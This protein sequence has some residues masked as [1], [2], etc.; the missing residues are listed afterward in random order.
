MFQ[1]AGRRYARTLLC[2][3][4]TLLRRVSTLWHAQGHTTW[5]GGRSTTMLP[6]LR[7]R[8]G[9]ALMT[10]QQLE[11]DGACV[12]SDRRGGYP[13]IAN[14]DAPPSAPL[15]DGSCPNW[16]A[17]VPTG[18]AQPSAALTIPWAPPTGL[19]AQHISGRRRCEHP[20][21]YGGG[22]SESELPPGLAEV[23]AIYERHLRLERN[24]SNHTVRAYRADIAS[25]LDHA[26]RLGVEDVADIDLTTLRSW[27]AKQKTTGKSRTT[28]AR[29]AT[30]VRVFT[31]WLARTGRTATDPGSA[32]VSP[33]LPRSLPPVLRHDEA[34]AALEGH[35]RSTRPTAE[36][37]PTSS[38]SD[39]PTTAPRGEAG[40]T[41]PQ[42]QPLAWAVQLRDDAM[43][44]LLYATGMRVGELCALDERD[45][46]FHRNVVRVFGKGRR[47]RSI[48]FGQ[49]AADA[50]QAWL[51]EGRPTIV[52]HA[53]AQV[54]REAVFLGVRGRR[55]D[56]RVVRQVVHDR[57]RQVP[58]APDIGPHGLRHSAATHLLEGG[59]DLRSVQELLGHS[60]LATTQIYTHVST[61]R[62]RAAYRQAH[63][64]A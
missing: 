11:F 37:E 10:A 30:A 47:E 1:P 51:A 6:H 15:P 55:I 26:H 46:D 9:E 49:P 8:A 63:P 32:L 22:V 25:M 34:A 31:G 23:L 7:G 28:M 21:T 52:E 56:Q 33:K 16:R 35:S 27:L 2:R 54:T 53:T 38:A 57:M 64:R 3:A 62:L 61:D 29:R 17:V 58:G 50:L 13:S 24:L 4:S 41:R 39:D 18:T 43:L 12:E 36:P 42:P 59:A 19:A 5:R 45:L 20:S 40:A 60:S 48:P 14:P 44:E